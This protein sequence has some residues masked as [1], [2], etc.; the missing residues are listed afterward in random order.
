MREKVQADSSTESDTVG[1]I[2]GREDEERQMP[3]KE[4]DQNAREKR[5]VADSS[6]IP[7][8]ACL[9]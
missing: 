5:K 3:V 8:S 7:P 1:F 9:S 2:A 6:V 4:G